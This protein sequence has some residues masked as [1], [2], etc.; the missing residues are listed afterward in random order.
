MDSLEVTLAARRDHYDGFG[1]TTNPKYSFKYQPVDWLAFRGAY[2]TGFKVP[3]FAQLYR[4]VTE[5]PYTGLDLADPLTCPGGAYNPSVAGC[6]VRIQPDILSGGNASLTPEESKQKSIGFVLAPTPNFNLSVDW[7]E[8]ERLNTIRSGF[9]LSTMTANY[10]LYASNFIRDASGNITEIDQRF[11]NTGGTLTSGIELDANLNGELAGGAWN[12]HLN[13]SYLDNFQTKSFTE[14]AY[15]NNLVGMYERY[16]NLPIKW[17]HTLG[18]AWSKGDWAHSLT[19]VYRGGYDDWKPPGI[20]NGSLTPVN[21]DPKVDE[22]ITY[23]YSLTWVGIDQFKVI[24]GVR[25]LLNTDPPFTVR[26]LDDG[27]GAAWE[28]R[29]ADPRGRSYNLNFEFKFF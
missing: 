1:G 16:F 11:I 17:K 28:A 27:D 22:Y 12:I 2:S 24:L 20:A 5:T 9:N 19:Q 29:V 18:F 26:Y 8:I 25:N 4:G 10:D 23:N 21:W 15:S 13:G 7:W 3:S 6:D 14:S